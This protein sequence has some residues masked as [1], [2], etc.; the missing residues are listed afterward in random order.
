MHWLTPDIQV[1]AATAVAI[2]FVH[3]LIGPDHYVPFVALARARRWTRRRALWVTGLCG[4]GHAVGSVLLGIIG[5]VVGARLSTLVGIETW[6]GDLA[7]WG[8]V[9]AGLIY[10]S[11]SLRRLARGKPHA[12]VHTHADGTVHSHEHAHAS[13]HVHEHP[14]RTIPWALFIVFVLGPCEALIPLLMYP[15]SQHN[16]AGVALITALFVTV[17]VTTMMAAVWFALWTTRHIRLP[18]LHRYSGAIAGATISACGLAVV[19]GL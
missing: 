13:G 19:L 11:I 6:R 3:T 7:A 9:A 15:A 16:L 18:N 1:L 5:I 8:L 4:L 17:T 12:H 14:E 2:A 10:L